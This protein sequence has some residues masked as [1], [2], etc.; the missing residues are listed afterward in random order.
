ME[1]PWNNAGNWLGVYQITTS[2]ATTYV[3]L[4]TVPQ[5]IKLMSAD[6]SACACY[7]ACTLLQAVRHVYR[8]DPSTTLPHCPWLLCTTPNFALALCV[9]CELVLCLCWLQEVPST[10]PLNFYTVLS[11]ESSVQC[12]VM[13][14]VTCRQSVGNTRITP[15]LDVCCATTAR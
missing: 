7:L 4:C 12:L 1:P 8:Q 6:R 15:G 11:H 2:T 14:S 9:Y 5:C 10:C 3:C 13:S